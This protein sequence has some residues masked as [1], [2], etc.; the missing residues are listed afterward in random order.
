[1]GGVQVVGY[2]SQM[3]DVLEG[4]ESQTPVCEDSEGLPQQPGPLSSSLFWAIRGQAR[5][6]GQLVD[7]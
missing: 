5:A 4:Q 2:C 1:M 3:K 7:C 6:G